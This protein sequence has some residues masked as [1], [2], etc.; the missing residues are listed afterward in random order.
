MNTKQLDAGVKRWAGGRKY[1][2]SGHQEVAMK[3]LRDRPYEE[4]KLDTDGTDYVELL[5]VVID[6]VGTQAGVWKALS[7][8]ERRMQDYGSLPEGYFGNNADEE[9]DIQEFG[10]PLI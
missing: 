5:E 1:T 10:E 6:R 8:A 2:L 9:P 3:Q 7:M 4:R